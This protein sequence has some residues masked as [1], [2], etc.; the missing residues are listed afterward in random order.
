MLAAS[1]DEAEIGFQT[2]LTKAK[3]IDAT[4]S[5]WKYPTVILPIGLGL[6]LGMT[7]MLFI[8]SDSNFVIASAHPSSAYILDTRSG[9][10]V[11]CIFETC[12]PLSIAPKKAL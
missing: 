1:Y 11:R 10:V 6:I 2:Y 7:L 4:Y 5:V 8:S 9:E 12:T 3:E